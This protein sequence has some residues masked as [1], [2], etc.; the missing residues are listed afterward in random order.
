M[1]S[2]FYFLTTGS[3]H[4]GS[5]PWKGMGGPKYNRISSNCFSLLED[6]VRYYNVLKSLQRC[7][8]IATKT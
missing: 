5:I 7:A 3:G 4:N 8:A 2:T 6:K 1:Q